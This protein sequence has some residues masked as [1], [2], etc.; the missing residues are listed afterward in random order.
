MHLR[1]FI[2]HNTFQAHLRIYV[3]E[4]K[5]QKIYASQTISPLILDE[6]C[7]MPAR[8]IKYKIF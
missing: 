1:L 5:E 7:F 2:N 6:T 8:S 3:E 4:A